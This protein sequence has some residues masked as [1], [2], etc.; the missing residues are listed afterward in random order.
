[1]NQAI[2]ILQ[3][4]SNT[5]TLRPPLWGKWWAS[6]KTTIVDVYDI[7]IDQD[8]DGN[9]IYGPHESLRSEYIGP[10]G[11]QS[12]T[13]YFDSSEECQKALATCGITEFVVVP[14]ERNNNQ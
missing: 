1:M 11:W 4:P 7:E 13:H 6:R 9:P 5:R 14:F 10:N 8:E 2:R 3:N 12:Y